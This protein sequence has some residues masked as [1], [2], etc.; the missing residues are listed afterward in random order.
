IR[1]RDGRVRTLLARGH[2]IRNDSGDVNRWVGVHL[3]ITERKREEEH[4]R[5]LK[6][7]QGRN[8]ERERIARRLH[9]HLQQLLIGADFQL[10]HLTQPQPE[11]DRL[12]TLNQVRDL[13]QQSISASRNLASELNPHVLYESG[14]SAALEWLA[15]FMRETHGLQLD[16]Q[17]DIQQNP[18]EREVNV[19][20]F[21]AVRELLLNVIKHSKVDHATVS[22][23]QSNDEMRVVVKD[24]G[25]G[26]DLKDLQRSDDP[27]A[28]LGLSGVRQSIETLGGRCILHSI[29]GH[30][31]TVEL[32]MPLW[33][34]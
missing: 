1:D 28:G 27:A 18:S 2:A 25:Q 31:T 23:I 32:R 17:M 19:V 10:A 3:D 5:A 14:F 11:E 12:S 30:G 29:P 7:V 6:M 26:F 22:A 13:L 33:E 9:D 16:L 4:V 21:D 24:G 8:E 34:G 15:E 20:L